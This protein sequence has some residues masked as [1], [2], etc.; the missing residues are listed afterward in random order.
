[1][2]YK[3]EGLGKKKNYI[4]RYFKI[5]SNELRKMGLTPE[6][7]AKAQKWVWLAVP[8]FLKRSG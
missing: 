1:M 8:H 4:Y 6:A 2:S 5:G 3:F 7:R